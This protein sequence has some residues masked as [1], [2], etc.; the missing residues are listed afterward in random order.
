MMIVLLMI[1]FEIKGNLIIFNV[2]MIFNAFGKILSID[3]NEVNDGDDAV[4]IVR[5]LRFVCV[6]LF[7]IF[8]QQ[9]NV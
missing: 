5:E 9:V 2:K 7:I 6:V 3:V 1:N 8:G 4:E